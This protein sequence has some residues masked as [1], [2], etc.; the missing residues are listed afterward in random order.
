M[1]YF[2]KTIRLLLILSL[3]LGVLGCFVP[4]T[5]WCV[6]HPINSKT[7]RDAV[8]DELLMDIAVD[9][10]QIDVF[11]KE[12]IVTLEGIVN[13]ILAKERA[14]RIAETVKGVRAVV[15]KIRVLPSVSISDSEIKDDVNDSLLLDPAT[16]SYEIDVSVNNNV[17]TLTGTVQSWQERQLCENVAKGVNGVT[18]VINGIGVEYKTTRS[19]REIE[20]EIEKILKWDVLVDHAL[21]DMRVDSGK[22]TLGGVV[23]SAAEKSIAVNDAYIPGVKSVDSRDLE[24]KKWAREDDLRKS[25]YVA[26]S[27]QEIYDAVKDA[28]M[29]D[30]RVFS[31]NV[32][33][34]VSKG[35]VTLRGSVDNLKAKNSAAQDARNTVGVLTVINRIKVRPKSPG[36]DD[37]IKGKVQRALARDP[38]VERYEISVIS[39]NGIVDLYGVVDSYFEKIQAGD[40]ASRVK[41][42][43]AVDN[44][45]TVD[46]GYASYYH[47]PYVDDWYVYDYDWYHHVPLHTDKSDAK[48][49][50]DIED[51]LFWSP[52]V[53]SDNVS[54]SVENGVAMLTG[55]VNSSSEYFAATE[56]AYEGGASFVENHLVIVTQ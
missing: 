34:E 33:P 48:I 12:G 15:N 8:E 42:V 49:K 31:F 3:T 56:N 36:T 17:V 44:N 13:N 4:M 39:I 50:E 10:R 2:A 38:Y 54:V 40:V 18:A 11:C 35:V 25:K 14:G 24:V 43:V 41:G 27:D 30:P 28:L 45:L 22:V 20:K 46:N 55:N 9:S 1:T 5:A 47:S 26:K 23:G 37:K 6:E 52:F 29:Y 53:D 51:E 7:V 21:I 19:D 16:D 32:K